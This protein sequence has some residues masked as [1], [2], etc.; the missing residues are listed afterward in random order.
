MVLNTG[1]LGVDGATE[2]IVGRANAM[3]RG[4]RQ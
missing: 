4:N 1:S 2:I 3:W